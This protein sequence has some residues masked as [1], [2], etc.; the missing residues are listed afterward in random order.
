[1]ALFDAGTGNSGNYDLCSY[2]ST[3]Y[4]TFRGNENS[5][6][7]VG[8]KN[9][10]HAEEEVRIETVFPFYLRS[11]VLNILLKFH[12]YEEPVY[13]IYQIENQWNKTGFGIIGMLEKP[14]ETKAFLEQIKTVFNIP[15]IRCT[16]IH[17]SEIQRIALCGGAG[18]FLIQKAKDSGA[19]I[20]ITGDI[21]YHEFF[22]SENQIIIAD[23]GHYESEQFTKEIFYEIIIK[24]FSNFAVKISD[25]KTNPINYF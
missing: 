22:L 17:K 6:P 14:I 7:F 8:E 16:N 23:I 25:I 18:S 12:P 20:F 24:K 11:K 21:K 2:N 5:H 13:D 19:D 4:G 15:I 9:Q 1:M 3:G 10:F